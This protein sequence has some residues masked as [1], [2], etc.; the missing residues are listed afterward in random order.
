MIA[1]LPLSPQPSQTFSVLLGDYELVVTLLW[2]QTRLYADIDVSGAALC[3]GALCEHDADVV[4]SPSILFYGAFRFFDTQG[5]EPPRWEGL[6]SRWI[7]MYSDEV[8]DN[9]RFLFG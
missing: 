1:A 4:Q 2:R 5:G 8:D 6:G 9:G 3:R 7:L